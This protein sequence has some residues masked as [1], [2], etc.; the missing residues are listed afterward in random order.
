VS[1]RGGSGC[2]GLGQFEL[3]VA[4][5]VASGEKKAMEGDE[6]IRKSKPGGDYCG[7]MDLRR[8]D[9]RVSNRVVRAKGSL[10]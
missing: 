9:G 4:V 7:V 6:V 8:T 2:R 5:R 3:S 10:A 1:G